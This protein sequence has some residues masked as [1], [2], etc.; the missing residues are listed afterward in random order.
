LTTYTNGNEVEYL[1]Y[2]SDG[3]TELN[4]SHKYDSNGNDVEHSQYN[5]DG[6][7]YMLSITKYD[8]NNRPIEMIEYDCELKFGEVQDIPTEKTTYKYKL[9]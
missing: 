7:L 3:E 1:Q 5:S 6:D 4:E 9:Y 2:N 8:S